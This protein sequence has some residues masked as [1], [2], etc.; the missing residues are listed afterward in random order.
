MNKQQIK[1]ILEE[2][3]DLDKAIEQ[4]LALD[5]TK[6]S[7]VESTVI[8]DNTLEYEIVSL[9]DKYSNR[10]MT[11]TDQ[12]EILHRYNKPSIK[13]RAFKSGNWFLPEHDLIKNPNWVIHSVKRL[14]DGE[15]FTIGDAIKERTTQTAYIIRFEITAYTLVAIIDSGSMR[16]MDSWRK[17]VTKTPLFKT[18]DGVDIYEGDKITIVNTKDFRISNTDIPENHIRGHCRVWDGSDGYLQFSSKQA[19]EEYIILN[20][21]CLSLMDLKKAGYIS[22]SQRF[23]LKQLVKSKNPLKMLIVIILLVCGL[24]RMSK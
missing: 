8:K 4:I 9:K 12:V 13:T 18:E 21:P 16:V 14:S 1:Q 24:V 17:V 3:A 23:S 19:A 15:V 20:K 11:R 6:K 2:E 10:I 5:K 7:K 22:A